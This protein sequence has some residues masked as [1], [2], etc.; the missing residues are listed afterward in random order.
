M[1]DTSLIITT[2][3]SVTTIE[4]LINQGSVIHM[5]IAYLHQ[6]LYNCAT[7]QI[8]CRL[9]LRFAKLACNW[10]IV[11]TVSASSY[12]DVNLWLA[13]H[14]CYFC[15]YYL[16]IPASMISCPLTSV[17][18]MHD[19]N[20]WYNVCMLTS[21]KSLSIKDMRPLLLKLSCYWSLYTQ[22]ILWINEDECSSWNF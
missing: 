16:I 14:L 4:C 3:L 12:I 13:T 8:N 21:Y 22:C 15:L 9:Q 18:S 2:V 20:F 6:Q 17:H 10:Q 1:Q 11:V 19:I 5:Y 7:L